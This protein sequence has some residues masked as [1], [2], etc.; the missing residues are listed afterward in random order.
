M[1]SSRIVYYLNEGHIRK[2][3]DTTT[4]CVNANFVCF[5]SCAIPLWIF[6]KLMTLY[7]SLAL[8]FSPLIL[9]VCFKWGLRR[10]KGVDRFVW[11]FV[12]SSLLLWHSFHHVERLIMY[13]WVSKP[14]GWSTPAAQ[15]VCLFATLPFF[16]CI[17]VKTV[18][19]SNVTQKC[20]KDPTR[21]VWDR[22]F[23]FFSVKV[24]VLG[25]WRALVQVV[26][27][28]VWPQMSDLRWVMQQDFGVSAFSGQV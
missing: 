23:T 12:Y 24:L 22:I 27:S 21:L 28:D 15:A 18:S 14:L 5:F 17:I 8:N 20:Y 4:F 25:C 6:I 3:F 16:L 19:Q 11:H 26:T 9:F 2:Y 7:F 10:L 1:N 13:I